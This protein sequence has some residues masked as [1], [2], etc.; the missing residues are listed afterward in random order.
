MFEFEYKADKEIRD[1][2]RPRPCLT[3]FFK[4]HLK[5]INSDSA[6]VQLEALAQY[7]AVPS[8]TSVDFLSQNGSYNKC[9]LLLSHED[10]SRMEEHFVFSGDPTSR[11]TWIMLS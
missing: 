9:G 2:S 3:G 11:S 5:R 6:R 8:R 1:C 4:A 10:F 7:L